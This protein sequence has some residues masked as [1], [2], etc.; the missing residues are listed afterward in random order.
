CARHQEYN[1]EVS[2]DVW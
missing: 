2:L 1:A